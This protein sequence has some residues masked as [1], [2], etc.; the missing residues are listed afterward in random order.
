MDFTLTDDHRALRDAVQRFCEASV[1]AERRGEAEPPTLARERHAALGALGVLGL[2]LP[3]EDGGSGLPNEHLWLVQQA[4]GEA[5]SQAPVLA[6]AV[7]VA[8]LLAALAPE[9]V[10]ADWLPALARGERFAALALHETG[11]RDGLWPIAT[12]AEPAT[13]LGP[14]AVAGER[15]A[16]AG[17]ASAV[18]GQAGAAAGQPGWRLDGR[19][20]LVLGGDLA[21][22][23][24][25]ATRT[26]GAPADRD[27]VTLFWL[28]ADAPGLTRRAIRLLDQRG[29]AE[30][31]LDGVW[32]PDT[33]RLGPLHGAAPWLE[34]ARAR[35]QAALC[36]DSAGA[37][38][39]LLRLV[40]QHL[41]DRRQFGAPLAKFQVLQ[42]RVADMAI[43]LEQLQSM[44]LVAT[45]ALDDDETAR[46]DQRVAAAK[47][48]AAQWGRAQGLAAI[49]LFGAMGMTDECRVGHYAKRL[50]TN[51]LLFG[52][53]AAQLTRLA[54]TPA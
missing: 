34:A 40:V 5:L 32:L 20:G 53:A 17:E 1:P 48:L 7:L 44:A 33:A 8:P 6:N 52:D 41:K 23:F 49:Q 36:A 11:S 42:H 26:A 13:G 18:A 2:S 14:A 47:L 46:R 37:L 51:G 27:G 50:I 25:V 12:R 19:K 16:L 54:A 30:L 35:A 43:A 31:H 9:A 15:A 3:E 39:A 38:Q 4:L 24:I 45:L 28:P 29:A 10:R 22:G 21:E